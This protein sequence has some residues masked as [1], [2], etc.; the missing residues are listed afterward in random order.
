MAQTFAQGSKELF[1]TALT[2]TK[3]TDVEG[4]G[5]IRQEG[6]KWY[7]WVQNDESSDALRAGDLVC[8]DLSQNE[9][10][11]ENVLQPVTA[12]L[13]HMAGIAMSAIAAAS[14]GWIQ[15]EGWYDDAYVQNSTSNVAIAVGDY[16]GAQ[17]ALDCAIMA[18]A[19]GGLSANKSVGNIVCMA[20]R[21][22]V[23]NI[24]STASGSNATLD[25]W[26][27]CKDV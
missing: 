3:T 26:V 4:V 2:D 8:Y 14:Y 25:V 22:S 15:I 20:S 27:H 17:N 10:M 21:Q 6:D 11:H 7:R 12:D 5:T 18:I 13:Y 24:T 23:A 9:A 16:A 19:S 1:L